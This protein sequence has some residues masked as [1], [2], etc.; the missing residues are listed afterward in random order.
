MEYVEKFKNDLG[1]EEFLKHCE[2]HA[3]PLDFEKM[4]YMDFLEARRELMAKVIRAA[5]EKL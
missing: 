5:F 2:R 4:E 3:L 1:D